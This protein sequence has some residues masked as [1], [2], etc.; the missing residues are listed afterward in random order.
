MEFTV[1]D[2]V[3]HLHKNQTIALFKL[4]P[5]IF[6]PEEIKQIAEDMNYDSTSSHYKIVAISNN[7]VIGYCGAVKSGAP[8]A[9]FVDWFSV[10]PDYQHLGVGSALL[11]KIEIYLRDLNVQ[12]YSVQTCSCSGE[13]AARSFY[14]KNQFELKNTEIDGYSPGHSKLTYTKVIQASSLPLQI[15]YL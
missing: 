7:D 14:K 3:P 5:D 12:E 15:L 2:F 8:N 10:H 1:Q 11:N 6:P 13:S 9:W 4:R